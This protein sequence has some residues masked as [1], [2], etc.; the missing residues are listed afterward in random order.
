ME[1]LKEQK[2]ELCF[3]LCLALCCDEEFQHRGVDEFLNWEY[4]DKVVLLWSVSRQN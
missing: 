2:E 4:R 3:D 1:Q